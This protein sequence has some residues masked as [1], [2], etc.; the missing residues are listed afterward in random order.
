MTDPLSLAQSERDRTRDRFRS[1]LAEAKARLNP[2]AIASDGVESAR[3]KISHT[4]RTRPAM[5][6]GVASAV[7]LFLL[8]KPIF[9][10]LARLTKE[11]DHG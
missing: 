7:A 6:A 11:K 3:A 5:I 2:K 1:S 8:R 4:V 9:G 10:A